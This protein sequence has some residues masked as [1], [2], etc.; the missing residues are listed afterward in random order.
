MVH[1]GGVIDLN[2]DGFGEV[3]FSVNSRFSPIPR[4][5][6]AYDIRHDSL[7][8]SPELGPEI[9]GTPIIYDINQD[10]KP[11]ILLGSLNS[12]SQSW[13]GSNESALYS[14]SIVLNSSLNYY[15]VPVLFKSRMSV[16]STFPLHTS[17]QNYMVSLSWPL[18]KEDQGRLLLL[19]QQGEMIKQKSLHNKSFVFDQARKNWNQILLFDKNGTVLKYNEELN[20]TDSFSLGFN[21]NQICY[22]DIDKDGSNEL[23]VLKDNALSVYR[24]NITG[25][26]EIDIPGLGVQKVY[27]SVRENK[28]QPNQL[29]IQ[30]D[31]YQYL[32]SYYKHPYYWL[33]YVLYSGMVFVSLLIY[34]LVLQWYRNHIED[35]KR[36][37]QKAMKLQISLMKNQLDPHFLFNA[38]NSIAFS[39][40]KDDRKTAYHTLGI[41]SKLMRETIVSID[42]FSRSLEDELNYVKHYLQLEKFRF[43]EQFN[44]DVVLSPEVKQSIKVPKMCIFCY[45]ES[46]LKKGILPR[47]EEGHIEIKIDSMPSKG[48]I[49]SISDDGKYRNIMD[50]EIGFTPSMRL[51]SR[52]IDFFNAFNHQ[53]IELQYT[54]LGIPQK[55]LGSRIQIIVPDNYSF[56]HWT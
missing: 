29:S 45:V 20:R 27:F 16:T 50:P 40:N 12:T 43:K 26:L 36:Q 47:P 17:S 28:D 38:L 48:I 5:V 53:K 33:I 1:P 39:I 46:A 49:V 52:I 23:V 4:Q 10:G 25:P 18:K 13:T 51:M 37:E 21:V 11:E 22:I 32:V 24:H 44:Y 2:G 9:V 6:F 54:D 8:S 3:I 41:F 34:F 19:N 30:N 14:A 7:F 15:T 55:P 42:D 31:N 56:S 35:L